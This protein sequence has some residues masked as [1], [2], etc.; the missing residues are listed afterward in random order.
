MSNKTAKIL[1]IICALLFAVSVGVLLYWGLT[2]MRDEKTQDQLEGLIDNDAV[3]IPEL[4]DKYAALYS[5][6]PDTAGWLS[7]DGTNID[8]VVMFAP[9]EPEKYL[10]A[11]FYGSYSYRGCLY[12]DEDCD[13]ASSDNLI[14]YGHNMKD[15]SMFADLLNYADE[16]FY[17]EH[18]TIQFDTVYAEQRFE[19]VA[20][21]YARIPDED[22]DCFRYYQYVGSG[23]AAMR[24]QYKAFL[25]E[26][27]CYDTGIEI[28]DDDKLITLSTCAYHVQNGRFIVVARLIK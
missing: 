27:Q 16:E 24:A 7:I 2:D 18:K 17:K 23:D 12:I 22:E 5:E 4:L 28:G 14:I 20:A 10:H 8:N 21:A 19:I 25:E 6:N 15:G 13:I 26:N 11:D 9:C 3:V 1:R